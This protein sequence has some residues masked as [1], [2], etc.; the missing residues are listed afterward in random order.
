MYRALVKS[1]VCN[2]QYT[3]AVTI[4]VITS[5]SVSLTGNTTICSGTSTTIASSFGNVNGTTLYELQINGGTFTTMASQAALISAL[6]NVAPTSTTTYKVRV[7]NAPCSPVLSNT[8]TVNVDAATIAGTLT[9]NNT[10]CS[11]ASGTLSISGNVGAVQQWEYSTDGGSSWTVSASNATTYNY[12]GITT[13][14]MYRAM[15]K[16]GVCNSAYT[17]SVTITV[18][19]SPTATLA[20]NTTICSGS[21]AT[22]TTSFGNVNGTTLYELQINGGTFTTMAS[23]AALITALTNISPAVTSTYKVRVTN[24]PCASVLSN[25]ITVNVDAATVAGTLSA[26]NTLCAPASGTLSIS[27]S[28][29]LVQ[30]WEYSTD[31]GST[32]TVSASSATTY[33]Y[34]AI[35]STTMYR[36]LVKSGVCNTQYTNVITITVIPVPTVTLT[37]NTTICQGSTTTILTSFAN[38]S[39][40]TLFELQV[41]GGSFTSYASQTALV[42]AL[43]NIAPSA[44]TTYKVRITNAPC[45]SVLSNTITINVDPTTVAGTLSASNTLCSPASGTLSISGSVGTVQQ[46]EYS[47]DGGATWTVS[48]SNSSTYNYTTLTSTTKYRALVKSGTCASAYTN[49]VTI[50]VITSP[51]VTLSG[52]ATICQ[53]STTTITASLGATDANTLYEMQVNSGGFTSMGTGATGQAALLSALANVGPATTSTYQVRVTNAPCNP[54]VSNSITI[55]VNS[56]T[57]GGVITPASTTVC[58]STNGATLTLGSFNGNVIQ[59]EYTT[60]GGL[61]WNVIASTSTSRAY[62]NLTTT[63]QYRALVKNGVCATQYSSIATVNVDP[64]SVG[65]TIAGSA[66]ICGGTNSGS[67]TLSGQVGN[68]IRWESSTNSG[69]SWTTIVNTTT[70][71]NYLNVAVT[72]WYR[73]VVQSGVC[74]QTTSSNAIITIA[75]N[76]VADFSFTTVCFGTATTFSNLST[77]ATPGSITSYAWNFGNGNTSAAQNPAQTYAVAGTY[78]VILTVTSNNGCTNTITKSVVVNPLPVSGFTNTTECLGNATTFTPNSSVT[79]AGNFIV[80]RRWNFGNGTIIVSLAP[81][82]T[83]TYTA[84]GTYTV[85]VLDSTNNGCTSTYSKSVTVNPLPLVNFTASNECLG[86]AISF[87]NTSTISSG[88]ISGY[89]WKFGDP[90]NSTSTA[91]SPTFTYTA[92]GAYQVTLVATTSNG[93]KDSVTK[94]IVVYPN[95][96]AGFNVANGCLGLATSFSNTS[97]ISSGSITAYSWNFGDG[98]TSNLQNPT[99]LYSLPG[100]YTITLTAT[101]GNLC[102]NTI[103]KT[104]TIFPR[105]TV[106]F[107]SSNVCFGNAMNFTNTSTLSAGTFTTVWTFGDGVGSSVSTNP[108]YTYTA[109]GTYKVTLYITTVNGCTDSLSKFVIVNPLPVVKFTAANA[110]QFNTVQFVNQTAASSGNTVNAY[111]WSFGD[112]G[113]SAASDPTH[114]YSLPGTYTVKLKAVTLTGCVDSTT[115]TIT[116][117]PAPV[118]GF[119]ANTTCLN[120]NMVFTNTSTVFTGNITNYFWNFGDN[121][122]SVLANPVHKYTTAGTYNVTLTVTSDSGCTN[123]ILKPVVV[124]PM[125]VA[126]FNVGDVCLTDTTYFVNTSSIASGSLSFK[127]YFGDGDSSTAVDP[128]HK[129]AASGS[130]TVTLVATSA[131]GCIDV[132]VRTIVVN[133]KPVASFA[134]PSVCQGNVTPFTNTSTVVLGSVATANWDFGDFTSSTLLNPSHTYATAGTYRVKLTVFTDKGCSDTIS[135]LVTVF[136]LPVSKINVIGNAS[137]CP[138]DNTLLKVAALAGNTYQWTRNGINVGINA[139]SLRVNTPGTYK[140]RVTNAN[141][142]FTDDSIVIVVFPQAILNAGLDVTISKGYSTTLN[143]VISING[144]VIP[145]P[146]GGVSYSWSGGNLN[147]STIP[148]PIATPLVTTRYILKVTDINGC[149]VFDT[150]IVNVEEDFKVIESNIITPNGDGYNDRWYIENIGSYTN[151]EVSIFNRWGQKIWSTTAYN[152]SFGWDGTYQNNGG[153]VP[154]GGYYYVIKIPM[155]NNQEKV[156]KGTINVLR[157]QQ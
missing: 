115:R 38:V 60:D 117:N 56:P 3:N 114:V 36:A 79:G 107:T 32:W 112:G 76:P 45:A 125:P 30:Q 90:A 106:G 50:T 150:V 137:F 74:S 92:S 157:N 5:P 4:T 78:T 68:V 147:D 131:F 13:T 105:A 103:T 96:I 86:T 19:L 69:A 64:V 75:P 87:S 89:V 6:S 102:T 151:A 145:Y 132:K 111:F 85:T 11:P 116:I 16:S 139:D 135:K 136:S 94:T 48:A 15:V 93:C 88:T 28:V 127:Y 12:T 109:A 46:W 42:N 126:N 120:D 20:G 73:A 148:N 77:I 35:T 95:P 1:G 142:C 118:A 101:S 55:T 29:G 154:D 71:Q 156:Y 153:Q 129:Y 34:S 141:G 70:N 27:G 9:A 23:Q 62:N 100:T 121:T 152:N 81:T 133:P 22:I 84:A 52:T 49:I 155:P 130:Y 66:T 25:T 58:A 51:S 10:Q 108:S 40:A 72:T 104:V 140:I 83:N 143:A 14:T 2:P 123:T 113:T 31:G 37:G 26:S 53:G 82:V 122:T 8:I 7:T 65:G 47:M 61:N 91:T 57:V 110:C 18:I 54:V 138:G 146:T 24:A 134:A 119:T 149:F 80:L 43:T 39:A 67:L 63:T 98:N 99:N 21:T 144:T 44:T 33:N 59:W 124:A 17:N 128:K 97:T 41:N